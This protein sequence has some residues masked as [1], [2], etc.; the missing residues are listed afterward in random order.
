[1]KLEVG[2]SC[3]S[4]NEAKNS[5]TTTIQVIP[6]YLAFGRR[7]KQEEAEI[8]PFFKRDIRYTISSFIF[9]I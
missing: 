3:Y 2:G 1:M 9:H 4:I 6:R 5:R 8:G 7:Q